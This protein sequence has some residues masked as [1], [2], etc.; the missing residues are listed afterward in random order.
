MGAAIGAEVARPPIVEAAKRGDVVALRALI[1][2][3]ET[4][5][6]L[7]DAGVDVNAVDE[8]GRTALDGANRLK[9]ESVVAWLTEHGAKP[10]T[11]A[12]DDGRRRRALSR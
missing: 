3:K 11:G 2:K 8:D 7:V 1:K 5:K 6:L 9:Y 4:I 12:A 10:G